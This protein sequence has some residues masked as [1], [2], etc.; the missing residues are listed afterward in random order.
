MLLNLSLDFIIK[1]FCL[2]Q[3]FKN[4]IFGPVDNFK[5]ANKQRKVGCFLEIQAK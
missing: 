4:A 2:A 1:T 3:N 5:Q